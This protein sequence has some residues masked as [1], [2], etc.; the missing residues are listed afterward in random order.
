VRRPLLTL[1]LGAGLL[2][3]AIPVALLGR[4]ALSAPDRAEAARSP[5]GARDAGS[6]FD[7]SADW[8]LGVGTSEPFF[9]VVREYLKA[10]ADSASTLD[11][12]AP[13]R[14]AALA[15]GIRSPSERSQAHVMVGAV[16]SFPAGN[17][18]MSFARMRLIGGSRL[19]AQAVQELRQ[20]VLLNDRNEAAKFD[21]ELVLSSQTPEFA[22]LSK[23]RLSAPNRP[24]ARNQHQGQDSKNPRNR[25]RLKQG[26]SFGQGS[27]Y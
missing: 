18:S 3:L 21:L 15:R 13:V 27:G 1:A 7:R 16:F 17:G 9:R 4:S 20:A 24:N 6:P 26:G 2:A 11:A 12:G 10:T 8:L 5:G 14:L 22:A 25:R 23:R 19:L